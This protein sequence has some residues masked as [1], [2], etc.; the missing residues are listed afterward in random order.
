MSPST[1]RHLHHPLG[2]PG[3]LP[4]G[5]SDSFQKHDFCYKVQ[6]LQSRFGFTSTFSQY[7]LTLRT[8]WAPFQP[9]ACLEAA[10]EDFYWG[11]YREG[12]SGKKRQPRAAQFPFRPGLLQSPRHGW[13]QECKRLKRLRLRPRPPA[14]EACTRSDCIHGASWWGC[15]RNADE[16]ARLYLEE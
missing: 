2:L 12:V 10:F 11:G 5:L 14:R 1:L 8:C 9:L 7:L 4:S 15:T 3:H 16:G 13:A 6:R